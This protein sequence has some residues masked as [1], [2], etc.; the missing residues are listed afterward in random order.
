MLGLV[1]GDRG[2]DSRLRANDVDRCQTWAGGRGMDSRL[3]GKDMGGAQPGMVNEG[4]ILPSKGR[5]GN[6]GWGGLNSRRRPAPS[7]VIPAEAGI[8]RVEWDTRVRW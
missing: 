7:N 6:D 2:M 4:S 3:R 5:G 8:H 1:A